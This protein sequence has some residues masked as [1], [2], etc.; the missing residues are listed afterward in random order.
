VVVIGVTSDPIPD[1][2][3]SIDDR[4]GAVSESDSHRINVVLAFQFLELEARMPR[5]VLKRSIGTLSVPLN[6]QR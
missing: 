6:V 4:Q 3:I 1:H 2:T 5:I